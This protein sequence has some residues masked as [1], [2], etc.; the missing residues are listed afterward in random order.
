MLE[1]IG[2]ITLF[3]VVVF[4][5]MYNIE[6]K[7]Q[8]QRDIKKFEQ[9]SFAFSHFIKQLNNALEEGEITMN[10]ARRQ[11]KRMMK[12]GEIIEEVESNINQERQRKEDLKNENIKKRVIGT[13]YQNEIFEMFYDEPELT[14]KVIMEFISRKHNL[15]INGNKDSNA[16][17]KILS[18]WFMNGLLVKCR[19]NPQNMIIGDIL[20][21]DYYKFNKED[22]TRK[23]W[24]NA[25]GVVLKSFSPQHIKYIESL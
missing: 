13:L 5:V 22:L 24:L 3:A 21:K 12:N 18:T 8:F 10:S 19:C 9:Y 2:G 15:V 16:A 4:F 7:Q 20:L 11:T 6:Q 25:N 17:A 1:S 14:V 23:D